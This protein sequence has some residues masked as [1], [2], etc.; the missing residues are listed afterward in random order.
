M[1]S[2]VTNSR[3]ASSGR[4]AWA[5]LLMG[6]PEFDNRMKSAKGV[7]MHSQNSNPRFERAAGGP[8]QAQCNEF[9]SLR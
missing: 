9:T 7:E 3:W 1:P 2:P 8:A 5:A 4:F 6:T